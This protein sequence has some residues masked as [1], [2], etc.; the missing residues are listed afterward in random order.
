MAG[1]YVRVS[2]EDQARNGFSLSEQR[3]AC[4][5]RAQELGAEQVLLFADEG[6]S[7]EVLERPG[8]SGLR[9]AVREGRVELIFIRDADRLS[10]R[11]AHQL[12]L[13]EEFERFGARIEFLDSS[14][15]DTPEGRLFFSVRAAVAEFE[16]EKIRDRTM[17]GKRQKA[18]K[19]GVPVGFDCYGYSFDPETDRVTV[20]DHEAQVVREIFRLFTSED[21]G[22][23]GTASRLNALGVPTRRRRGPWRK[24]TVR[25]ILRQSAYAGMWYYG[26]RDCHNMGANR[27]KHLRGKVRP[28]PRQDWIGVPMPVVIDQA[29]WAR[30]QER[31]ERARRLWAGKVRRDY[32]LS[33]LLACTDCGNSMVGTLRDSW[34]DKHRI[35]TC[36]RSGAGVANPGCRPEKAVRADAVEPAVWLVARSWLDDPSA[37]MDSLRDG[38]AGG[39]RSLQAELERI[40]ASLADVERGREALVRA[41][42]T[43]LLDLDSLTRARLGEIRERRDLLLRRQEEIGRIL[44]DPPDP[45]DLIAPAMLAQVIA[46][47]DL[48]FTA[49]KKKEVLRLLIREVFVGGGQGRLSLTIRPVP[50]RPGHELSSPSHDN[51]THPPIVSHW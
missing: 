35:Y 40:T 46:D 19:G 13:A 23:N 51:G 48:V 16:K 10:R 3:E 41:M 27:P 18:Q 6:I 36:R 50:F 4:A 15:Q 37:V 9:D 43:G 14:Y 1:I 45:P 44:A 21:I 20:V 22:I 24:E 42:A 29:I 8:L 39:C 34:G 12:L 47:P 32:L 49:G 2:T 33:G 38:P 25:Q 11:L 30:A 17:R 5:A 26:R 31:L 7:G 28:R